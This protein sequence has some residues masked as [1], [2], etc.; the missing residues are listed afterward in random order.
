MGS[1]FEQPVVQVERLVE[2]LGLLRLRGVR[3]LAADPHPEAIRLM[4]VDLRS[5]CCLV[6]GAEGPG[7]SESVLA[8]CDAVVEIPMPSH[9]NSLN[10]ATC[11]AVFL[12][13][14]MRQRV[15]R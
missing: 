8:S 6:F 2:T 9:M 4:E 15:Q 3:C 11:A 5:D 10:V 1:I 12:Y 13:E 14:A 7:L